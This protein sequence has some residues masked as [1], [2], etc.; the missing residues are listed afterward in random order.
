MRFPL[1]WSHNEVI[2]LLCAA[3]D[4]A[5]KDNAHLLLYDQ[6][7]EKNAEINTTIRF[8]FINS[9]HPARVYDGFGATESQSGN[10]D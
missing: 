10:T 5:L 7:I 1:V 6:F 9:E 8:H 3:T 4:E 2:M